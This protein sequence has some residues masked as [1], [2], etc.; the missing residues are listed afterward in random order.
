MKP[1]GVYLHIPFCLSKCPY[2]DFY[3]VP[4]TQQAARDYTAALVRAVKTSPARGSQ[5]DS[6]YFGGGTPVLLGTDLLPILE[7]VAQSYQL[8]DDCEITLEA[9]PAAMTYDTLCALRQGDFNRISMDGATALSRRCRACSWRS[10]QA[11]RIFR[12]V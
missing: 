3:S 1:I 12:S 11:L 8:T 9:N 6:V 2:C 7:E 4:Y 5:V 10:R